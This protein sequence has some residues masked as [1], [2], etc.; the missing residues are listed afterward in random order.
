MEIG[1]NLN[2]NNQIICAFIDGQSG[3]LRININ[4]EEFDIM[5]NQLLP[6]RYENNQIIVD[7]DEIQKRGIQNQI[8]TLKQKLLDTDYIVTKS[9]EY[10]IKDD[11]IPEDLLEIINQRDKWRHQIKEL[12]LDLTE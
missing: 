5:F 6:T 7:T 1:I 11:Q 4:E 2:E 10:K 9:M 8:E 3:E 12:E